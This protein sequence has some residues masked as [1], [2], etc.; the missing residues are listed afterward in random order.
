MDSR[1]RVLAS[2]SSTV[3]IP[4]VLGPPL[5][6][7]CSRHILFFWEGGSGGYFF[8][9]YSALL[10]LPPLRFDCSEGCWDRTQDRCNWCMH[11]QSDAL[12]TKLDLIRE[13]DLIH[14]LSVSS[15]SMI[16][17]AFLS[18]PPALFLP[19]PLP[20]GPVDLHPGWVRAGADRVPGCGADGAAAVANPR[21][22]VTRRTPLPLRR[23]HLSAHF[24]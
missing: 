4:H 12:T 19:R 3:Y 6:K 5:S 18:T 17:H 1:L 21:D 16:L 10:H 15:Q 2:P 13:L 11:W 24:L 20:A 23:N 8:V 9:L 22:A 14:I 7:R